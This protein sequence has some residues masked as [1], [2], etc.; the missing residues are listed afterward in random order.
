MAIA[1]T[2][3]T[4]L[5]GLTAVAACTS[6]PQVAQPSPA[7]HARLQPLA[8]FVGRWTGAG[9]GDPGA[10][11]VERTYTPILAGRFI[12]VRHRSTYPPQEKNPKGEI[13][14]DVGFLSHDNARKRF[15]LRQFHVE[16][17]FNQYVATTESFERDRLVFASEAL[18]NIPPGMKARET[19]IFS[20]PNAFEEIFEIA[21][22]GTDYQVYSHNHFTRA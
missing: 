18:E 7:L 14:D 20:G 17:F 13:H 12:E 8:G 21:E 11:T 15:V 16:G 6:A 3:R 4:A 9:S 5:L 2:R 19:Y 10:S 1:L 22:N